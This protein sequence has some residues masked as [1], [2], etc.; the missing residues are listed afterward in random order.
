MGRVLA[1]VKNA[2]DREEPVLFSTLDAGET[3]VFRA[4]L[5]A[6]QAV[7]DVNCDVYDWSTLEVGVPPSLW[8]T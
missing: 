2:S 5:G 6:Q 1:T 3:L 7:S 4:R 8:V